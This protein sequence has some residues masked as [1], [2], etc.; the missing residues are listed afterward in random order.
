MKKTANL[1][2]ILP[3]L[4][5]VSS[6]FC[7][8]YAIVE[9]AGGGFY[10]AAVAILFAA[11]FDAADGRV[12]RLTRTQSQFGLQLDSLADVIS[13]GVAPAM[14]AYFWA[15]SPLGWLGLAGACAYAICGALR[16]ARFN[17]LSAS[18]SLPPKHFL[19]LPIPIAAASVV[20]LVLAVRSGELGMLKPG[21]VLGMLLLLALL[22]VSNVRYRT[23]K[24]LKATRRSMGVVLA[25]AV[26]VLVA[27]WKTSFSLIL[28]VIVNGFVIDGLVEEGVRLVGRKRVRREDAE[29]Q[30]RLG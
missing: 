7:G 2:L 19:G 29:E 22:M 24:K 23:F 21:V 30:E 1:L 16:L 26:M 25:L 10:R 5:T 11:V 27:A 9:A 4:F 20:S 28:A 8:L 14:L 18:G 13:F 17:V 6:I 15:L 3:N 12:A